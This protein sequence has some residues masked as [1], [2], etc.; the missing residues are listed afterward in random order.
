[1]E[2][3]AKEK[4]KACHWRRRQEFTTKAL[5]DGLQRYC[6]A[7]ANLVLRVTVA[8]RLGSSC[9]TSGHREL[10]LKT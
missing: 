3:A 6:L 1:M 8:A 7:Q 9:G 5:I 10:Q 2:E 4:E